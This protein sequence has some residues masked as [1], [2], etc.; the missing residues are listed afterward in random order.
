MGLGIR[1]LQTTHLDAVR[2]PSFVHFPAGCNRNPA[3]KNDAMIRLLES[4][5]ASDDALVVLK[6][7]YVDIDARSDVD[8][9]FDRYVAMVERIRGR[10]PGMTVVHSTVPLAT[11][12]SSFRTTLKRAIGKPDRR[13]AAIAR[14]R[15]NSKLRSKYAGAPLFDIADAEATDGEGLPSGFASKDSWVPT[16]ANEHSADGGHL[17]AGGSRRAASALLDA[18]ASACVKARSNHS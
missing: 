17:N 14:H 2:A 3:S 7:C 8:E 5:H 16:L 15:Y 9:I 6:Y 10:H 11:V 18:L 12:D 13:A 1:V 4:P